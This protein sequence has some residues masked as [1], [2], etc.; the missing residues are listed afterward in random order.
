MAFKLTKADE[1]RRDALIEKLEA[2]RGVVADEVEAF[3]TDRADRLLVVDAAVVAYNELLEEVR[4]F[5]SDLASEHR[6]A[7]DE[8][9]EKW[10]EGDKASSVD[11]WISDFESVELDDIELDLPEPLDEPTMEHNEALEAL[12]ASPDA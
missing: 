10:Q 5:V 1:A 9:S 7:Y 12:R 2:A 3:N 6:E 11:E 4:G 8:M